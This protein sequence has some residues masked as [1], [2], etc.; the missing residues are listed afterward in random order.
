MAD[1]ERLPAFFPTSSTV[2]LQKTGPEIQHT[3]PNS[4]SYHDVESLQ[5][6]PVFR[7]WHP[8]YTGMAAVR[9]TILSELLSPTNH[10]GSKVR[11]S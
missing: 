2:K 3:I 1:C 6:Q 8:L 5:H 7:L 4:V 11:F 10:G 9:F